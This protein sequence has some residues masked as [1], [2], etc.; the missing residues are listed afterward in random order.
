MVAYEADDGFWL[1]LVGSARP[2]VYVI[3]SSSVR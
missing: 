1:A 3:H 2:E